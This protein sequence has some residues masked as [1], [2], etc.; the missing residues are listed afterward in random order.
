MSAELDPPSHIHSGVICDRC[1]LRF[2][3]L[4]AHVPGHSHIGKLP[5]GQVPLIEFTCALARGGGGGEEGAAYGEGV[6]VD[7]AAGF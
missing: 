2:D 1:Y 3:P 6:C 4:F 7:L 5:H